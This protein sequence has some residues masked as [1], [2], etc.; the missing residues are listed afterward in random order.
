[1]MRA[2]LAVLLSTLFVFPVS[3]EEWTFDWDWAVSNEHSK[4]RESNF[5]PSAEESRSNTVNA[6]LDVEVRYQLWTGLFAIKSDNIYSSENNNIDSEFVV[7]E[8]FNQGSFDIGET[9]IDY[10]VGKVRLDWGVG[11]GYRPLDIFKP[12]RR[13]PVG[14]Q[15]EEG[16]G[17]VSFSYF[18]MQ[19]EWSLLY[20]DS[21][22]NNQKGSELQELSEQQGAGLRRYWL[23][24]NS[25]YQVIAYVDDVRR[26]LIGASWVSVLDASWEVHTSGLYQ[27]KYIGY[28]LPESS[29]QAVYPKEQ[30]DGTQGLVGVTWANESGLQMIGEY[31]YDNRGWSDSN[32]KEAN[33]R[34]DGF[35]SSSAYDGLRYSYANGFNHVN[36]VQHNV[37]LHWS[38]DGNAL[39]SMHPNYGW[40][41]DIT[42]TFDVIYSPQDNGVIATQWI[43]YQLYDSGS[44]TM[45]MEVAARFYTGDTDSVYANLP[46][47]HKVLINLKGRF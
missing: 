11:Y 26:G 17:V 9:S 45:E 23:S 28:T 29:T 33:S 2:Q 25:E 15:V 27:Q 31:W 22:W 1:M 16:A 18:D 32:W 19:G 7:Q 35:T 42:P 12:Y 38:L 44:S 47:R 43:N 14:I 13:N 6:L 46:D 4:Y 10:L 21:S 39:V 30:E 40:M 34:V 20:T 5:V 37:M 41:E 3:G 24:D 8:L 36:L